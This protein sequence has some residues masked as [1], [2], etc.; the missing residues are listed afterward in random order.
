MKD[1][2]LVLHGKVENGTIRHGDKLVIA[3]HGGLGQVMGLMDGKGNPVMFATPGENVQI[4]INVADDDQVQRGFVIN[5]R[6]SM[7]P[8]TDVFE[9]EVDILE[10][11]EYKPIISKGYTCIMHIHT[12]NDEVII[13]DIIKSIE[14]TDKGEEIVKQK[15]QFAKSQMRIICR[16]TP[17]SPIS[18]EKFESISQMGRFTLRDEG[19]T[20]CIGRVLRYKPYTKGAAGAAQVKNTSA[21]KGANASFVTKDESAQKPDM[22]YDM[23]TGEMKEKKPEQKLDQIA[24][25]DEDQD[26]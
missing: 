8:V 18:L 21:T 12:F 2:D 16:M 14:K 17:K 3:P 10:L 11:L 13:K 19:K 23:E 20:I 24:E 26:E 15:P 7:M 25:G 6:D 5:H 1:K 22:V 4:K 9:A